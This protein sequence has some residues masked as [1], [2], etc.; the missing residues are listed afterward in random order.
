MNTAFLP[1]I[2]FFKYT[3]YAY[4]YELAYFMSTIMRFDAVGG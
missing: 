4:C 3:T 2:G 1:V